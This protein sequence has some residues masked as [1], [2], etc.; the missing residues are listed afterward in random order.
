LSQDGPIVLSVQ[1]FGIHAQP[2]T[3]VIMFNEQLNPTS[4][5]NPNNYRIVGPDGQVIALDAVTFDSSTKAVTLHPHERLD[6]HKT[7]QLTV[8]GTGPN[9]VTDLSGN[10][11]DGARTGKPGSDFVTTVTAS[12]LVVTSSVP[13]GPSA[14]VRVRREVARIVA[15]EARHAAA[16]AAT[17]NRA[18]VLHRR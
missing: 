11:L 18:H 8:V 5:T 3:L 9:G 1:R 10:L 2:T 6:L 16:F 4:A 14:L 12:N 17:H 15:A 13:G 7:Y